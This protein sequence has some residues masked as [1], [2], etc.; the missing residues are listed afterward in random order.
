MTVEGQ[1]I[2]NLGNPFPTLRI[3]LAV[4]IYRL[5][6]LAMLICPPV[7]NASDPQPDEIEFFEQRI[8]PVLVQQCYE[9]HNT[10]ATAEAD[11]SLDHRE[12]LRRG[13]ESGRI[14]SE[15][16]TD[17]LLLKVIRHEIDGCRNARGR[18][19]AKR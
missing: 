6:V 1:I 18:A 14:I 12:A 19:E 9:C 3:S 17:S 7:S 5:T 16:P 2:Y 13:G 10:A 15:P 4:R 11:L 8:R